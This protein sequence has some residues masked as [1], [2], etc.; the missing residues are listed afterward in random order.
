MCGI[1]YYTCCFCN[2]EAILPTSDG[3]FVCPIFA[4]HV[5]NTHLYKEYYNQDLRG[6]NGEID[7]GILFESK[8]REWSLNNFLKNHRARKAQIYK[9]AFKHST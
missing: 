4:L 8:N 2:A 1:P 9:E 5:N 7:M 6:E 3:I